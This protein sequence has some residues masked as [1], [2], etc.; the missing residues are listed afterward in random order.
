MLDQEEGQNGRGKLYTIIA[1]GAF[2]QHVPRSASCDVDHSFGIG[3]ICDAPVYICCKSY[4]TRPSLVSHHLAAAA[5]V[6]KASVPSDV[7]QHHVAASMDWSGLHGA[8]VTNTTGQGGF[9]A[10]SPQTCTINH[11]FNQPLCRSP[12]KILITIFGWTAAS[13]IF[14]FFVN[15]GFFFHQISSE[16]HHVLI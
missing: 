7:P 14:C 13:E 15:L 1:I 6:R 8:W 3:R 2:Q 5:T 12:S 11:Y 16:C 4:Q 9:G 10:F